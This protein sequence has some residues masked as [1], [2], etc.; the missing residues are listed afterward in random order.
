MTTKLP[1]APFR[2]LIARPAIQCTCPDTGETGCFLFSGE[3]HRAAGSRVTPVFADCVA[4]FSALRGQWEQVGHGL[5][6]H[7]YIFL[8]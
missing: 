3:T 4:L 2:G 1:H 6:V 5:D 7:A 8:A